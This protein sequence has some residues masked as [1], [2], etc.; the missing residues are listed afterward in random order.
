MIDFLPWGIAFAALATNFVVLTIAM[1]DKHTVVRKDICKVITT[2]TT[3]ILDEV[4]EDLK[5]LLRRI[6]E[7]E[8]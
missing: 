6:P 8:A 2:Q 1:N 5:E 7:K 3:K 4:K